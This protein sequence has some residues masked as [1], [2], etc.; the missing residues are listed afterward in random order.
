M[1]NF[2]FHSNESPFNKGWHLGLDQVE[3]VVHSPKY[4]L[5]ILS[6]FDRGKN[7]G[8]HNLWVIWNQCTTV[9]G[10]TIGIYFSTPSPSQTNTGWSDI[11]VIQIWGD[12]HHTYYIHI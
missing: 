3:F 4:L 6:V 9:H 10:I 8:T 2:V 7:C 1:H 11:F 12:I 5:Q